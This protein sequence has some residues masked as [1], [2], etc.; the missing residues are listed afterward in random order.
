DPATAPLR[1]LLAEAS[2]RWLA[3]AG[4]R[5]ELARVLN[6]PQ[7]A[8]RL[9]ARRLLPE[10]VLWAFDARAEVA[11]T[12]PKAPFTC[13]DADD[14]KFI[15]LAVAHKAVLLSKDAAVLCMAKRLATL[16]VQVGR[17]WPAV[18]KAGLTP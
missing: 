13:K 2:N 5:E 3:T 11:T 18:V 6:Y 8:Q 14:Q 16:G 12:A 7:I 10:T 1:S 17:H 15:D 9:N 4:M